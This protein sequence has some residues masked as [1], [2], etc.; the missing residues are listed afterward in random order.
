[1]INVKLTEDDAR[2]AEALWSEYLKSHDV[3]A[4][5]GQTVGIEP[6]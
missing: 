5:T 3:S 1:M 6:D 2:R 4:M